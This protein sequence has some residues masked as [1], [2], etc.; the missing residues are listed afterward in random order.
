MLIDA[1]QLPPNEQLEGDVCIL[2][3]GAAG[4]TLARELCGS[5]LSVVLVESGGLD[6]DP[7]TQALARGD[8]IGD[9]YWALD[10]SRL[11]LFGGTTNHWTGW[12]RPFEPFDLAPRPW[13]RDSGWPLGREELEPYYAQAQALCDLGELDYRPEIWARRLGAE[14]LPL[15][16]TLAE[17]VLWQFSKPTRFGQKYRDELSNAADVRVYLNANIVELVT[18]RGGHRVEAARLRRLDGTSLSVRARAF[19]LATGGIE[20]AR[21]LLASTDACPGGLGNEQDLV[22]RFFGEHPHTRVGKL[23]ATGK[24]ADFRLYDRVTNVPEGRPAA[25]RAGL[26]VPSQAQ[27]DHELLGFSATLEPTDAPVPGRSLNQGVEELMFGLY[28]AR[29]TRVYTVYARTEQ[30]P[31]PDSRIVL[32]SKRDSLGVRRAALDWRIDDQ[33]RRS[34][35]KSV[36]LIAAAL[37]RAGL[38]RLYSY[39]HADGPSRPGQFPR[40]DG[41]FH[42]IGTTRMH[43][44]PRRGVVDTTCRLHGVGNLYVAGSS[45]FSTGGF[46]NPTL[47]L[48]ALAIRL[49][50]HLKDRAS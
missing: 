15:D 31:N 48:V 33:T 37:A 26:T 5:G 28:G 3:A 20:N 46:A 47:T 18:A 42:H 25:V 1:R 11:R 12:C 14:L 34:I 22:G 35:E 7:E 39:A 13:V 38:G 50:D 29:G 23:L 41:G 6:P 36:E 30:A 32:S 27:R 43:P 8:V 45:V 21:L 10:S 4:I 16:S 2:G 24:D 19:V 40:V 17:T 49:A 44:D 9:P